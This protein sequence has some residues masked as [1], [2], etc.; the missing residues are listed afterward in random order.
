MSFAKNMGKNISKIISKDVSS[1]YSQKLVDHAKQSATYAL[2]TASKRSIQKAT[3][4]NGDLIGNKITKK[5]PQDN[6]E[7][8]ES[9]T[10]IPK[11]RYISPEERQ[12]IIDKLRLIYKYNNGISK[13]NKLVRQY[14]KSTIQI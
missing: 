3:E 7:T 2:K 6:S 1:K 14:T 11:E 9:E 13:N 5:S 8:V 4:A 10:E 12:R